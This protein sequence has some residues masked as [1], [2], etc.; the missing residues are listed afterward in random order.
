MNSFEYYARY[1]FNILT[2]TNDVHSSALYVLHLMH[3]ISSL[4]F[5]LTGLHLGKGAQKKGEKS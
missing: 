4:D 3:T 2:A 1:A 5:S